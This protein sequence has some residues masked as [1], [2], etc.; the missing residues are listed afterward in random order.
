[1][2]TCAVVRQ[3]FLHVQNSLK[4]EHGDSKHLV[5]QPVDSCLVNRTNGRFVFEVNRVKVC[6]SSFDISLH[7]LASA[8]GS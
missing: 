4:R 7:V 2:R 5:E 8:R 1:M 3:L 6:F